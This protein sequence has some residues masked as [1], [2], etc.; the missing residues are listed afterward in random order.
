[1][2]S[3]NNEGVIGTE[4]GSIYYIN[5][6]ERKFQKLVSSNNKNHDA[7]KCIKIDPTMTKTF[8]ISCG[9]RS[10]ELKIFTNENLEEVYNFKSNFDSSII[11]LISRQ[12]KE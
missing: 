3:D 2:D 10:E 9:Q 8:Y 5:L 1:M 4:S 7:I 12:L 6:A 11:Q